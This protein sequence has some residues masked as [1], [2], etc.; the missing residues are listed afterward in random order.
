MCF[1]LPV[2]ERILTNTRMETFVE[3][4]DMCKYKD[5]TNS[6]IFLYVVRKWV[7]R[8]NTVGVLGWNSWGFSC[9]GENCYRDLGQRV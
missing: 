8:I 6:E 4:H 3:K 2:T 9:S 5:A 7:E 1:L